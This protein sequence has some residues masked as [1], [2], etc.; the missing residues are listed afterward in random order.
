MRHVDDAHDA[1]GHGQ[2][3]RGQH[4]NRAQAQAEERRLHE[5]EEPDAA[6]DAVQRP[7]RRD[8]RRLVERGI[9]SERVELRPDVGA[10]VAADGFDGREP[11]R[12]IAAVEVQRRDRHRDR[13][14]HAAVGLGGEELLERTEHR[15]ILG[16]ADLAD[17]G[18][19]LVGILV[20][21]L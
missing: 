2:A 17:R 4:E 5:L 19:A 21:E 1:E 14:P 13:R 6:L 18:A 7:L 10:D 12:R 9:G 3:D 20:L 8:A 15:E 11:C 16:L